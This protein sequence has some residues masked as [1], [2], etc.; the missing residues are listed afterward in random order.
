MASGPP[1]PQGYVGANE[2]CEVVS[3]REVLSSAPHDYEMSDKVVLET[4]RLN[5]H[6]KSGDEP[7]KK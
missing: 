6:L 5:C 3:L 1:T 4:C 2:G 7:F